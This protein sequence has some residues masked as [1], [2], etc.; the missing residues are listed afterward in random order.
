[1]TEA[2]EDNDIYSLP[3][4]SID[5]TRA[6]LYEQFKSIAE[7]SGKAAAMQYCANFYT[8]YMCNQILASIN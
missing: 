8:T 1:M 3:I 4:N 2:F 7:K 6:K 5:D